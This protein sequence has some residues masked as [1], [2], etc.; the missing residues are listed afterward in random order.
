[1]HKFRRFLA[2]LFLFLVFF[3]SVGFS[4]LNTTQI[5]LS[6][7]FWD[8]SPKPLALWVISAFALGGLLGLIFAVGISN[9]FKNKFEIRRLRK[10]LNF[11]ETKLN[12]LNNLSTKGHQ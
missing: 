11:A 5:P 10:Q 4:F 8:F 12:K 6:L 7:G 3:I 2:A 9:F 1:M